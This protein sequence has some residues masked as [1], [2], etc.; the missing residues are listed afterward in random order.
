MGKSSKEESRNG[1]EENGGILFRGLCKQIVFL[2]IGMQ[3]DFIFE[4]WH[5]D[6]LQY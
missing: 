4:Y 1:D 5:R 6:K 2:N 3:A